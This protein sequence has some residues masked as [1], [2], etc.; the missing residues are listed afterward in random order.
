MYPPDQPQGGAR[1]WA[2]GCWWRKRLGARIKDTSSLGKKLGESEHLGSCDPCLWPDG[3][4]LHPA[5]AH[6]RPLV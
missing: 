2:G 6:A 1:E 5:L 3:L 4:S